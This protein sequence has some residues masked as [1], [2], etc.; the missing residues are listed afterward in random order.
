MTPLNRRTVSPL[1]FLFVLAISATFARGSQ[2]PRTREA[3]RDRTTPTLQRMTP[4]QREH[5]KLFRGITATRTKML[6]E[7]VST[8]V[9]GEFASPT[10]P[11]STTEFITNLMCSSDDVFI[12]VVTSVEAFPTEDGTFL[13]SEYALQPLEAFG[14]RTDAV[15]PGERVTLVRPGGT[16]MVEGTK[17]S[18]TIN[19][20]PPL[21]LG[22]QYL[23]F[24]SRLN[25]NALTTTTE[26]IFRVSPSEMKSLYHISTKDSPGG[27][28]A[29]KSGTI[30]QLLAARDC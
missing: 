4:T 7:K 23:L 6:D 26:G 19:G 5:A 13:F 22:G 21:E 27:P 29:V 18:A 14:G 24:A 25:T 3:P 17:I 28:L 20:Y 10:P 12:G 15:R 11:L 30:R 9:I 8:V 2:E 1:L 16:T